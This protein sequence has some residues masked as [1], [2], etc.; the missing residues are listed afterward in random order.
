MVFFWY[1]F[2]CKLVVVKSQD[3]LE[4]DAFNSLNVRIATKLSGR[5]QIRR[6]IVS[7]RWIWRLT[8]RGA[9]THI[10][11]CHADNNV[12]STLPI[13]DNGNV[14]SWGFREYKLLHWVDDILSDHSSWNR[15]H[16]IWCQ[17]FFFRTAYQ[18]YF[19]LAQEI[20]RVA[21]FAFNRSWMPAKSV[22]LLVIGTLF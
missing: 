4:C 14:F 1:F 19:S 7:W 16:R 13:D 6:I 2:V 5:W 22:A 10:R 8:W 15:T 9:H 18:L 20:R 12:T 11:W 17:W 21:Q 3:Y